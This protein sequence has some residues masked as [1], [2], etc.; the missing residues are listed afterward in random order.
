MS[1]TPRPLASRFA[2]HGWK[3]VRYNPLESYATTI[4]GRIKFSDGRLTFVNPRLVTS[5]LISTLQDHRN[6]HLGSFTEH[7]YKR[8]S[9]FKDWSKGDTILDVI[10]QNEP[11]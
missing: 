2:Q 7:S 10:A 3:L 9:K 6:V 8:K 4:V 11:K 5:G 1:H